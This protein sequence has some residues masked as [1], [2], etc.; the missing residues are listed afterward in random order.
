MPAN[1]HPEADYFEGDYEYTEG[2]ELCGFEF[3]P[4]RG[5]PGAAP[6][7]PTDGTVE[8]RRGNPTQADLIFYSSVGIGINPNDVIW[9]IFSETLG[10]DTYKPKPGDILTVW[11]GDP[12][13]EVER[14]II[15][16][17]KTGVYGDQYI[18]LCAESPANED[19][20][21]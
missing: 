6:A 2:V 16:N 20:V 10:P 11:R 1:H 4:D 14:W 18:C 17:C 3:G 21:R 13:A 19:T 15:K 8:A 5:F 9:T 7:L 12:L